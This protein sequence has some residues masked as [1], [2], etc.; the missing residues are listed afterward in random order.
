MFS[1]LYHVCRSPPLISRCL[2]VVFEVVVV[3]VVWRHHYRFIGNRIAVKMVS[4][5]NRDSFLI[6]IWKKIYG[7]DITIL[8]LYVVCMN[9]IFFWKYDYILP[10]VFTRL[11]ENEWGFCFLLIY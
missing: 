6:N 9:W 11:Q 1:L 2:T 8:G 4:K 3:D 10:C 7:M 5:E